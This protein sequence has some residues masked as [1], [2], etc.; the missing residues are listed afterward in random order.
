MWWGICDQTTAL[1]HVTAVI[2]TE[3][4]SI[5]LERASWSRQPLHTGIP[6]ITCPKSFHI[7]LL[8]LRPIH[9]LWVLLRTSRRTLHS[10]MATKKVVRYPPIDG[11]DCTCIHM[12]IT[13]YCYKCLLWNHRFLFLGNN[14]CVCSKISTRCIKILK[15]I[16]YKFIYIHNCMWN[17]LI[18]YCINH[19]YLHCKIYYIIYEFAVKIWS[20][21]QLLL[22]S[23]S[24]SLIS[25]KYLPWRADYNNK[26]MRQ[27]RFKI[28]QNNFVFVN[29]SLKFPN[30]YWA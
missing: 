13:R 7:L 17:M 27:N 29:A 8:S 9:C 18:L 20:Q 16:V 22:L 21:I 12:H 1:K 6:F 4:G 10:R 26:N 25:L 30:Q 11:S 19:S 15:I 2:S 23:L 3:R 14:K 28:S 5:D 24:I